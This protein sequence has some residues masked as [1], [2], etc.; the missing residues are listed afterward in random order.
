MPLDK[1]FT[2][3]NTLALA[4]LSDCDVVLGA[5]SPENRTELR[6]LFDIAYYESHDTES[7][8]PALTIPSQKAGVLSHSRK[9]AIKWAGDDENDPT[10]AR[11]WRAF[12]VQNIRPDGKGMTLLYLHELGKSCI[13]R[14]ADGFPY[15]FPLVFGSDAD[16]CI[17]I[18][19]A[20]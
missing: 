5:D 16:G 3:F 10:L 6:G 20:S 11:G 7:R 12:E 4:A 13:D 1:F 9:L 2:G 15:V 14:H 18:D 17:N 8:R 19:D